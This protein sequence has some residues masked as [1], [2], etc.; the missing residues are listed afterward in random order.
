MGRS[1]SLDISCHF[2]VAIDCQKHDETHQNNDSNLVDNHWIHDD[3]LKKR[4]LYPVLPV[5]PL[6]VLPV[7]I[8]FRQ[9]FSMTFQSHYDST[10]KWRCDF[11]F[12]HVVR[13]TESH[14]RRRQ[15]QPFRVVQHSTSTPCHR[16]THGQR[17]RSPR[18]KGMGRKCEQMFWSSL[19]MVGWICCLDDHEMFDQDSTRH[20]CSFSL[21]LC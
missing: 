17:K 3:N 19:C 14:Q 11:L 6:C 12:S 9:L 18:V 8:P 10:T 15:V 16:E 4:I 2:G 21:S 5:L 13:F 20:H 1:T 7:H